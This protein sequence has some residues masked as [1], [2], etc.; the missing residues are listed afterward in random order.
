MGLI[1][2]IVVPGVARVVCSFLAHTEY[3]FLL[4]ASVL[5]YLEEL[6]KDVNVSYE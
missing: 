5:Y 3:T 4:L 2:I 6:S 1:A